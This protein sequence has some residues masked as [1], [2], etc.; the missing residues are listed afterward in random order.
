MNNATHNLTPRTDAAALPVSY[1]TGLNELAGRLSQLDCSLSVFALDGTRLFYAAADNDEDLSGWIPQAVEQIEA[2]GDAVVFCGPDQSIIACLLR[3]DAQPPLAVIVQTPSGLNDDSAGRHEKHCLVWLLEDFVKTAHQGTRILK[4]VESFGVE[5]SKAYE[6]IILLYNL[7]THMKVT[8]STPAYLQMACDELTQLVQ[9]E[10]IAI[11][12][13]KKHDGRKQ[14]TLTAGA[15][16]MRIESTMVDV[17][18]MKLAAELAAGKEALLDSRIDGPFKYVWP[19]GVDNIIAVPLGDKDRMIGILI[20]VN[21]CNKPD[22]DST[23]IKLFNS[24]ANQCMVFIENNRLFDDLKELFAG[25]LKALTSS[26]DAK[27]QYTRGHSER[28]A[29]ISRWIAERM[30]PTQPISEK[31]IHHIYL[32]GL[33]HDIGKIGVSESVLRKR[34][35]L[36][37]EERAVI[38]AHPR[39]GAAILSEIRQMDAIVP[40]VLCHHERL[41]GKG[42]PQGLTDAQIPLIGK[43][44]SLADAFDAMTSKRVYRD[45]MSIRRALAEIDKGVGTQFDPVVARAFLDSDIEKLWQIIQDGF[46]ESWDYSNFDEYGVA[47]VGALLR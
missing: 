31:D 1:C 6:E 29:F 17:L 20:A 18:Q 37:D 47:A 19:D 26:I 13:D 28:V 32:A 45:A 36:T 33:L 24:V 44:L 39:I 11:Y 12:L 3:P 10:G 9:V 30:A 43:I 23:D 34:G 25:S 2:T 40:G 46:I 27:D 4:Q 35:K 7:S 14:L 8:Q 21:V 22:F 41:D 5:L 15:G 38:C 16:V 42:Y